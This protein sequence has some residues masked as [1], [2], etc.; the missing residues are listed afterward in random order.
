M[1]MRSA[2]VLQRGG[3]ESDQPV[4]QSVAD[5]GAQTR[6]ELVFGPP[7]FVSL[8]SVLLPRLALL[9]LDHML[10]QRIQVVDQVASASE[11]ALTVRD[12]DDPQGDLAAFDTALE[13]L[14]RA[15]SEDSHDLLARQKGAVSS[16]ELT[17]NLIPR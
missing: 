5:S 1:N 11:E 3:L 17:T 6:F 7:A 2:C 13:S 4:S 12:A 8:L 16:E 10:I 15:E 9:S 14:R